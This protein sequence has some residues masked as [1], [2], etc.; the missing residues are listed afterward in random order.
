MFQDWQDFKK[1]V[2]MGA[3][4]DSCSHAAHLERGRIGRINRMFQDWQDLK[5]SGMHGS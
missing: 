2:C 3:D 5:R 4:V 1:V